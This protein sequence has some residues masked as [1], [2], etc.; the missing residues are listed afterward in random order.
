VFEK[1]TILLCT[2]HIIKYVKNLVATAPIVIEIKNYIMT[3]F[4]NMLYAQSE[5]LYDENKNIF[6]ASVNDIQVRVNM[7][8]DSLKEQFDNNCNSSCK[9][10]WVKCFRKKLPT[11][12]DNTKN[13]IERSF[14]T[15]K[16]SSQ[17]VLFAF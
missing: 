15:L 11:L 3:K 4:K 5:E 17:K 13:R 9:I 1:A 10:M 7:K 14:W 16:Q 2:F 8:Y 12:G 6:L